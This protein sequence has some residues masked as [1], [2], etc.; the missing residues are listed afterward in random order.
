MADVARQVR[1]IGLVTLVVATG[2]QLGGAGVQQP[3]LAKVC[4]RALGDCGEVND[5]LGLQCARN[6]DKV[7]D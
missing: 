6:V 2:N 1:A 3:D 7:L 5:Q 4:V